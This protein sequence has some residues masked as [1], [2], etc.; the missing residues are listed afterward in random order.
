MIDVDVR[1]TLIVMIWMI[2]VLIDLVADVV[3]TGIVMM[4]GHSLQIGDIIEDFLAFI[5]SF[6]LV[7]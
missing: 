3:P 2:A 1:I 4:R 6:H 7:I 5:N